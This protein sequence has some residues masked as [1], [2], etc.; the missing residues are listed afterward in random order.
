MRTVQATS[1]EPVWQ[2][3]GLICG[4]DWHDQYI[5]L[6]VGPRLVVVD[7]TDLASSTFRTPSIRPS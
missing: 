1:V 6:A 4:L 3:G 5:Y 7:A 2:T